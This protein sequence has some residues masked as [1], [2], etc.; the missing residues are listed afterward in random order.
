MLENFRIFGFKGFFSHC[1][2]LIFAF[3]FFFFYKRTSENMCSVF[4]LSRLHFI[5]SR[6]KTRL[7]VIGFQDVGRCLFVSDDVSGNQ[8]LHYFI[9]TTID[10]LHSG[11]H[12]SS[13]NG[14]LPHVPPASVELHA[15]ISY[16][17]L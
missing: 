3:E 6:L 5:L 15:V 7:V 11:I 9:G 14:V 1:V 8:L 2:N 16:T 13:C 12:V 4:S 10:W 17:V